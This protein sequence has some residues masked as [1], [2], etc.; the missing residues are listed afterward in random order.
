MTL[1]IE[2]MVTRL[3]PQALKTPKGKADRLRRVRGDM[4]R[5]YYMR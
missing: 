4:G 2:P 5:E 3:N 1:D